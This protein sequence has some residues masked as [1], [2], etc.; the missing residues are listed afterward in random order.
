M[1]EVERFIHL[2]SSMVD[3]YVDPAGETEQEESVRLTEMDKTVRS[4]LLLI[5]GL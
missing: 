3:V 5:W 1:G 2:F 4:M